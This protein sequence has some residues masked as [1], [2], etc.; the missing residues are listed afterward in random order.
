MSYL[1]DYSAT[2][3]VRG[4]TFPGIQAMAWKELATAKLNGGARPSSDAW[5]PEA[6]RQ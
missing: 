6:A 2:L 3:T 5:T 4:G 1:G